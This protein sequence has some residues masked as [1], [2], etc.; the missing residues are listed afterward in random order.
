MIRTT[1][2]GRTIKTGA[3]YLLFRMEV[4][5]SQRHR[6]AMC[7]RFIFFHHSFELDDSCHLHHR[8]GRGM[9][10]SKRDDTPDM[11]VALCGKCHRGIHGSKS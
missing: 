6:C 3:D 7:G 5:E 2:D 10:G 1:K 4:A 8:N 9:G 11:C